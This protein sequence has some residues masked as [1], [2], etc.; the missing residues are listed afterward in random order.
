VNNPIVH[1]EILG[2]EGPALISFYRELFGW[3]L[4]DTAMDGYRSYAYLPSPEDGIGGGIGQLESEA[5]ALVTIYVEVTD[6][7]SVLDQAIQ[8][9]AQVVLPV[10]KI[11]GVGEIARF[12]DPQGN[13]VGVVR[14]VAPD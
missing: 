5:H 14:S 7:E 12:R 13:V 3:E 2:N 10:T 1:F 8:S 6:P 4:R 9:G 11:P